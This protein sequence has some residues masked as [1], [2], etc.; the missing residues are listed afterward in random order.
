MSNW[1]SIIGQLSALGASQSTLNVAMQGLHN[2]HTPPSIGHG[3]VPALAQQQIAQQQI[4]QQMQAV[5][6]LLAQQQR[7]VD[8][9]K[10]DLSGLWISTNCFM[11]VTRSGGDFPYE[12]RNALD[13][14]VERGTLKSTGS[15]LQ[16]HAQNAALGPVSA[17][18]TVVNEDLLIFVQ[19][20]A[21]GAVMRRISTGAAKPY[22]R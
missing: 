11:E 1:S 21:I 14:V 20:G 5:N 6:A 7:P 9:A 19:N 4:A 8:I 16:I 15:S 3:Q 17:T 22:L 18:L 2:S 12:A 10:L 13:I